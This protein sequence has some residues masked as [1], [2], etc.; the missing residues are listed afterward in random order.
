[1][2]LGDA[3]GLKKVPEHLRLQVKIWITDGVAVSPTLRAM[4]TNPESPIAPF[5]REHAPKACWGSAGKVLEWEHVGGEH[6]RGRLAEANEELYERYQSRM[7]C[8]HQYHR[9]MAWVKGREWFLTRYRQ[10]RIKLSFLI[11]RTAQ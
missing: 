11:G 4:L 10:G 8:V 1:M 9:R 7:M 6:G 2:D 5:L 3:T